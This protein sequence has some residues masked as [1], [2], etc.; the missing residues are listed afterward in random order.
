[1]GPYGQPSFN[2][3][4]TNL[5]M[6]ISFI[7]LTSLAT[8]LALP[9]E[10]EPAAKGTCTFSANEKSNLGHNHDVN[11]GM[12]KVGGK[13]TDSHI[14]VFGSGCSPA[15]A[16]GGAINDNTPTPTPKELMKSKK[17]Y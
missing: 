7:I 15:W 6:Q 2:K 4:I 12:I 16:V 8:A 17:F 3:R 1:M 5:I 14:A 13:V 10:P 11:T 9:V